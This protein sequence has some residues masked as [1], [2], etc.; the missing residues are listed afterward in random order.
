[1]AAPRSL[2]ELRL[3]AAQEGQASG[4]G[5]IGERTL[6]VLQALLAQPGQAAVESISELARR[7]GVDASTLT[8]LGQRLGYGGF[9]A[10]QDVFR[11][12]VAAT[13]PFY[14]TRVDKL[15]ASAPRRTRSR[16][17]TRAR[18]GQGE[19]PGRPALQQL[20]E[21]EFRKMAAVAQAIPDAQLQAAA[22]QI[23]RAR[24]VHVLGL[25]GAHALAYFFGYF[26]ANLRDGVCTLGGPG[27]PLPGELQRV[28]KGDVLVAMSF[29]PYTR[30]VVQAAQ[31]ARSIGVP[32]VAFSDGGSPF[33][34]LPGASGRGG[35]V[36]LA[37][38]QPY[39][40]DSSLSQFLVCEAVLRHCAQLLG[41]SASQAI[42]RRE[43]INQFLDI[44]LN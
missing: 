30:S 39:Y 44:E 1:M 14:S 41:A 7:H 19:H 42:R 32:V 28:A 11:Q 13:Q 23:V 15:V 24:Q 18:T 27:H 34:S 5:R 22:R 37:I 8:R 36:T 9:A 17:G 3:R 38:A 26:L 40:M 6:Q 16:T 29:R 21:D 43:A 31:Y 12:H 4:R 25:R 33:E 2:D 20:A 10:L 35:S